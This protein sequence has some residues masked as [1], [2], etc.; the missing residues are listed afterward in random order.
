MGFKK[1]K[2]VFI[3]ELISIEKQ[4]DIFNRIMDFPIIYL[5]KTHISF[6]MHKHITVLPLEEYED[7]DPNNEDYTVEMIR[8]FVSEAFLYTDN[9]VLAA[10]S[11]VYQKVI[12]SINE[13]EHQWRWKVFQIEIQEASAF[14]PKHI[15]SYRDSPDPDQWMNYQQKLIPLVD[16]IYGAKVTNR[17]ITNDLI[18]KNELKEIVHYPTSIIIDAPSDN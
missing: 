1:I 11:L 4:L 17:R 14:L 3:T 2:R 6:L 12:P 13:W 8:E 5:G 16:M 18:P 10:D 9:V 7:G 15:F